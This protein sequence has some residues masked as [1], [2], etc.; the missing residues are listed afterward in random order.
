M[1]GNH[2]VLVQDHLIGRCCS[3]FEIVSRFPHPDFISKL[4]EFL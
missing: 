2:V 3:D 1:A 4:G